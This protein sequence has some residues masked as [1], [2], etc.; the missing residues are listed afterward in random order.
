MRDCWLVRIVLALG[1]ISTTNAAMIDVGDWD[2]SEGEAAFEIPISITG[3][4][5]FKDMALRLQI[6]DG[7]AVLGG[8][9]GPAIVDIHFQGSIWENVPGGIAEFGPGGLSLGDHPQAVVHNVSLNFS[10]E[11]VIADGVLATLVID[12][13]GFQVGQSFALEVNPSF[14]GFDSTE[15]GTRGSSLGLQIINGTINI[16]PEPATAVLLVVGLL[17]LP[18]TRRCLQAVGK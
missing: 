18:G 4:E 9:D 15:L 16:V 1:F 14:A 8:T 12:V 10:Q 2:V 6:G 17:I 11:Q 7:G 5:S 13:R 3:G